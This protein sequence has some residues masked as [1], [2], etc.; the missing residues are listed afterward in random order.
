MPVFVIVPERVELFAK[1]SVDPAS[2][3]ASVRVDPDWN[4][5]KPLT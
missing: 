3:V 2:T 5:I 4:L 1:V